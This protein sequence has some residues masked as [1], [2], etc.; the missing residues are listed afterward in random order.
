[1]SIYIPDYKVEFLS[2]STSLHTFG[3]GSTNKIS[4]FRVKPGLTAAIGSFE[5]VIPD[6]GSDANGFATG[7]AFANIETY[8]TAKFWYTDSGSL[9]TDPQFEGRIDSKKVDFDGGYIRTFIG[10]DLGEGLFRWLKRRAFTGST[11]STVYILRDNAGLSG[12]NSYID[13]SG[14][15]YPIIMENQ[16]CFEALKEIS[17]F[18]NKDFYVDINGRLH[19]FE[20]QSTVGAETFI[21]GTNILSYRLIKDMTE[22]YN[23][24]AV[25]G[26]QNPDVYTGSYRPTRWGPTN[27]DDWTEAGDAGNWTG[28]IESG[29]GAGSLA[30]GYSTGDKATGSASISTEWTSAA[31]ADTYTVYLRRSFDPELHFNSGDFMA[32]FHKTDTVMTEQ[33]TSTQLRLKTGTNHYYYTNIEPTFAYENWQSHPKIELG[34][35]NEGVTV[36][37]QLDQNTGSYKWIRSGSPDWYNISSIEL[38]GRHVYTGTAGLNYLMIDGLYFATRFQFLTGSTTSQTA[39]GIR[40]KPITDDKYTSDEYCKN[41]AQT[42]LAENSTPTTQIEVVTLGKPDLV[43]GNKYQLTIQSEN[44]NGNYELIDLEQQWENNYFKSKC[45]FTNKK[46]IRTPIAL[47]NYPVQR[48]KTDFDLMTGRLVYGPAYRWGRGMLNP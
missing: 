16:N 33:C 37:T 23:I 21:E 14:N 48:V 25:F 3:S 42:L 2:G 34:P 15:L 26:A 13:A 10:R 6:T 20:R 24:Y 22:V 47:I 30:V 32:F 18:D 5:V 35:R 43:M 17:D 7:K 45:L 12:S 41:V 40:L 39:Y 1:M 44:I 36:L 8:D 28:Y 27:I 38:V 29:S 19:W 9:P 11:T 4:S 31:G 46:Q